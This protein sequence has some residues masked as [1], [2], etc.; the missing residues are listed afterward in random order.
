[1]RLREVEASKRRVAQIENE[2]EQRRQREVET[3][4]RN[5]LL[6]LRTRLNDFQGPDHDESKTHEFLD[7]VNEVISRVMN[8]ES[9]D[10]E[11]DL[12]EALNFD[13]TS[14]MLN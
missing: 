8:Y 13:P 11:V 4:S 6:R 14:K 12:Q 3:I 9:V 5:V 2:Y 1:M 7:E 10:N